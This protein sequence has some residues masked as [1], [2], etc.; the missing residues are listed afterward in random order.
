M[1]L[2]YAVRDCNEYYEGLKGGTRIARAMMKAVRVS[3][4]IV[5]IFQI[6]IHR[7][8]MVSSAKGLRNTFAIGDVYAGTKAG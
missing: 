6:S 2:I 3:S 8:S 7:L 1:C 4:G 5:I